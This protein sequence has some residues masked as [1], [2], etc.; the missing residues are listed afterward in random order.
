MPDSE[1]QHTSAGIAPS[2]VAHSTHLE[3]ELAGIVA[4]LHAQRKPRNAPCTRPNEDTKCTA[5]KQQ[6]VTSSSSYLPATHPHT[7][8]LLTMD[9][10]KNNPNLNE[11]S[12]EENKE[13]E[14]YLD[15]GDLYI[16]DDHEDEQ[17]VAQI[18]TP[19]TVSNTEFSDAFISY[20]NAITLPDLVLTPASTLT[21]LFTDQGD[22]LVVN[23][24]NFPYTVYFTGTP[25]WLAITD[26]KHD[27]QPGASHLFNLSIDP[28]HL[29]PGLLIGKGSLV[30]ERPFIKRI[31]NYTIKVSVTHT[32]PSQ[33][34]EIQAKKI[35]KHYTL[36]IQVRNEGGGLL[37]GKFY[38]RT[39]NQ[40]HDFSLVDTEKST[41]SLPFGRGSSLKKNSKHVF[42][43]SKSFKQL[44]DVKGGFLVMS[45]SMNPR[46]RSLEILPS[47]YFKEEAFA[48]ESFIDFLNIDPKRTHIFELQFLD[49]A[50]KKNV[51]VRFPNT[52]A[53]SLHFSVGDKPAT[54]R[55][56]LE[57][58][59]L[60]GNEVFVEHVD[61]YG[62]GGKRSQLPILISAGK[63]T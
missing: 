8:L 1:H 37:T 42:T 52:L 23:N 60:S 56:V 19:E 49:E 2:S 26:K 51:S 61:F 44:H 53:G 40:W 13:E 62:A 25:D 47:Q 11:L 35:T 28:S 7:P 14:E 20:T 39:T 38:D 33:V 27:L 30:I 34:V 46:F 9:D 12:P 16:E 21:Q 22:L 29:P 5:N 63:D 55:F 43:I 17:I 36:N 57:A 10:Q 50:F 18:E 6:P 15:E 48:S 32:G 3:T 54:G 45:N 59:M 24:S 4:F 41:P 31:Y 58:H